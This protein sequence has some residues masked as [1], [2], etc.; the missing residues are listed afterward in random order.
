MVSELIIVNE[1][2]VLMTAV[3]T[4][5]DVDGV[6]VSRHVLEDT[7]ERMIDG[8]VVN[9]NENDDTWESVLVLIG[10]DAVKAVVDFW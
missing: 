7:V 4:V 2:S 9:Q 3:L 1:V 8:L 6:R 10:L 5:W